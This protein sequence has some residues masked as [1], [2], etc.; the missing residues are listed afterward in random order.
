MEQLNKHGRYNTIN[1]RALIL[2]AATLGVQC[3][4]YWLAQLIIKRADLALSSPSVPLDDHIP[5]VPV[6]LIPYIGCFVHWAATFYLVY[7]TRDGFSRLFPSAMIGYIAAFAVFLV[8]P[9]TI[10]R[11]IEE[12]HGIL[13][14]IYGIICAADAPLNLFP[15]VHCMVA[16]L[17]MACTKRAE[18]VPRWYAYMSAIMCVLVCAS[19]V[20]VKQHFVMDVLGGV[21][22]GAAAWY[23]GSARRL[24][25]LSARLYDAL[26]RFS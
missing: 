4:T 23:I 18:G 12:A 25:D 19:T 10:S 24:Y 5:F 17:C 20:F 21:A 22:L 2:A 15:S 7:G 3:A 14:F 11:P 1:V 9:T 6:F 13:A 26:H 8:Y 16:F